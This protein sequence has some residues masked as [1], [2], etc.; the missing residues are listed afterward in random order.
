MIASL[1][2]GNIE[3]GVPFKAPYRLCGVL[4]GCAWNT[5]A[6]GKRIVQRQQNIKVFISRRRP[7]R[8]RTL[9]CSYARYFGGALPLA[10]SHW[11]FVEDNDRGI[12]DSREKGAERE[13]ET[14]DMPY[15]YLMQHGGRLASEGALEGLPVLLD[16]VLISS[17]RLLHPGT[18]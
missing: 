11:P 13:V 18:R 12:R 6:S 15:A 1:T 10:T 8:T 17:K 14:R 9:T 2:S 7:S 4:T 5:G 16:V 3:P